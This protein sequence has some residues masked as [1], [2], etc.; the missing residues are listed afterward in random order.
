MLELMCVEVYCKIARVEFC[1][2]ESRFHEGVCCLCIARVREKAQ[3]ETHRLVHTL[4]ETSTCLK[5][6]TKKCPDG[7]DS[8]KSWWRTLTIKYVC[9]DQVP[10]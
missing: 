5:L 7:R 6:E 8:E 10:K 9:S 4:M 2:R 3:L 1:M